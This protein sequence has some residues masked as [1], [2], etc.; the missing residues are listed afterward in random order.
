MEKVYFI[1][2]ITP[3][4]VIKVYDLLNKKLKGKVAVKVHSGEKVI[5]TFYILYF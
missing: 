1:K 2:E 5:K 3:E 4:N